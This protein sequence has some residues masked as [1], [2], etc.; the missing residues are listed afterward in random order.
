M[1]L[2]AVWVRWVRGRC[3][4]ACIVS[5]E[6][7]TPAVLEQVLFRLGVFVASVAV[8]V[9]FPGVA[10]AGVAYQTFVQVRRIFPSVVPKAIS[11]E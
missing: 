4:S 3:C 8:V 2:A 7:S 10:I 1:G 6:A 9:C 5:V 11:R